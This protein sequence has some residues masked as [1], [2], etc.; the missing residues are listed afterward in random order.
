MIEI[1]L[2]RITS[3]VNIAVKGLLIQGVTHSHG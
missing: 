1:L 2:R 3:L